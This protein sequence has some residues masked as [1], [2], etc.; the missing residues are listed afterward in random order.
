MVEAAQPDRDWSVAG[1]N[2]SMRPVSPRVPGSAAS[3]RGRYP[4]IA[5]GHKPHG[6]S[7]TRGLPSHRSG[8]ACVLL[9]RHLY[10]AATEDRASRHFV[11]TQ[12]SLPRGDPWFSWAG[13]ESQ[14]S[15]AVARQLGI[16]AKCATNRE[17]GSRTLLSQ[18]S[19][20]TMVTSP[21]HIQG[22]WPTCRSSLQVP[23]SGGLQQG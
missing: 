19:L 7:P 5:G 12:V 16:D 9:F 21:R 4:G 10:C 2:T 13:L 11:P 15:N 17:E 1:R 8:G 22:Y 14:A 20:S 18:G 6:N 3:P 23:Q